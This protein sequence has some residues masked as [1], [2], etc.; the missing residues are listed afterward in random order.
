[1]FDEQERKLHTFSIH[2]DRLHRFQRRRVRSL[3]T[4]LLLGVHAQRRFADAFERHDELLFE[5]EVDRI[6]VFGGSEPDVIERIVERNSVFDGL[7]RQVAARCVLRFVCAAL[8]LPILRVKITFCF[9]NSF[10]SHRQRDAV[11]VIQ[12]SDKVDALDGTLLG[13]VVAP[14][15]NLV[16]IGVRFLGDAVV[17]DHDAFFAFHLA[18]VGLDNPPQI[19]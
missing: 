19:G 1:M 12:T 2:R 13:V 7:C 18:N 8:F 6:H 10:E 4:S 16:F 14:A 3:A 5:G 17:R 11:T 15:D 9:P